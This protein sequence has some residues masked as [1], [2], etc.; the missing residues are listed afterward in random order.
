MHADFIL[1]YPDTPFILGDVVVLPKSTLDEIRNLPEHQASFNKMVRKV[2]HSK[3]TSFGTDHVELTSA[4]KV[5]LT[6][7]INSYLDG[8]QD[9]LRYGLDKELGPCEDWTSVHLYY[10]LA[11]IVALLSGRVFVGLPLSREEEWID[12]SINYTRDV[13]MAR[14]AVEKQPAIMR[15]FFARFLPE[16]KSV[17][18]YGERCAILLAPLIEEILARDAVGKS[19]E[20][21]LEGNRRGTMVSWI[22]KYTTDRSVRRIADDQMALTFAAIFTTT[23]AAS[24]VIFDLVSRPEYIKPLRD[25]IQQVIEEDGYDNIGG[26]SHKLKKQSIPKLKKLDSFMK[27]SQR[28]SPPTVAGMGRITTADLKLSTGHTIPKGVHITFP[29]YAISMSAQSMVVPSDN[30]E[31]YVPP[32]EFDGFRFFKLRAMEGNENKVCVDASPTVGT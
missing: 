23:A 12:A 18:R 15:P 32:H 31:S 7:H 17:K 20:E 29:A 16:V 10:Q 24:Q 9:E 1:K 19:Y 14:E 13:I 3:Y 8:L 5:D 27:E 6:R 30:T 25:E 11:R 4:V 21:D 26:K 22:L 28:F 2:M